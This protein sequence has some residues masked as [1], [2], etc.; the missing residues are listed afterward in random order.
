MVYS[1][2]FV[3]SHRYYRNYPSYIK[4]YVD[5][6]Q[7]F[8]NTNAFVLIVDNNSKHIQDIKDL[9]VDYNNTI[10]LTNE[11]E[12]KFEV[13]AYKVG[14]QYL[15]ENQIQYEY[16]VFSQDNFVLK[17]KFD[18]GEL[19]NNNIKACPVNHFCLPREDYYEPKLYDILKKYGFENMID[20]M[21]LCWCNTFVLHVS[22]IIPFMEKTNHIQK[23][24]NREESCASER[25]L[26]GILHILNNNK[27]V[28]IDGD[29]S[30]KEILGYDCW[31]V[32]LINESIPTRY[33][34]KRI[35]AKNETTVDE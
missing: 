7:S 19:T 3:I 30:S 10:I 28:S 33:F 25:Y 21:S 22:C 9:F 34:V 15:L 13:G 20:I 12:C 11:T 18:F 29:I 23:I 8:Y 35:Q 1:V 31:T 4:Y 24:T 5:N 17:R 27:S 2:V 32:D 26:S 6:I 14:I 16:C